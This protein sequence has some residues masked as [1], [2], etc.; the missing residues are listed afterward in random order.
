MAAYTFLIILYYCGIFVFL[1][2]LRIFF[3]NPRKRLRLQTRSLQ[4][5][6]KSTIMID[7]ARQYGSRIRIKRS[8]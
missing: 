1:S 8:T 4:S 5:G 3:F 2:S 6:M 7:D